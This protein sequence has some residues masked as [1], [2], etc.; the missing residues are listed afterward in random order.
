MAGVPVL[1]S[2]DTGP[3]IVGCWIRTSSYRAGCCI[4]L[5]TCREL[6]R[7]GMSRAISKRAMPGL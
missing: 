6:V 1:I 2:E 7:C 3:A 5:P 4:A